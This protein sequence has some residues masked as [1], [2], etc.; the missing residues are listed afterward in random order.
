MLPGALLEQD[1]KRENCLIILVSCKKPSP[2]VKA[3]FMVTMVTDSW[4]YTDLHL[5]RKSR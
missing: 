3:F 5:Q 1:A 4:Y 2:C